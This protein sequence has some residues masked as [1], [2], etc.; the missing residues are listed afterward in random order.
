MPAAIVILSASLT[1]PQPD[2]KISCEGST[3]EQVLRACAAQ[4]P[5]LEERIF[6]RDGAKGAAIFL[7][8]RSTDQ[9]QGLQTEI[10]QGDALLL[11]TAIAGG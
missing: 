6:G 8:G 2:E 11:L 1:Y 10:S 7:N 4:R 9:L 3:V 5:H